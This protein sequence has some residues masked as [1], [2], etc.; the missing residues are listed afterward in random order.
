MSEL[1]VTQRTKLVRLYK[2]AGQPFVATTKPYISTRPIPFE[3]ADAQ[4]GVMAHAVCRK[5][6]IPPFFG[7][8]VGALVPDGLGGGA[9][10]EATEDM[11]NLENP[12]STNGSED[13]VIE[14]VSSTAKCMRI[15]YAD[16]VSAAL[17]DP[18]VIASYRGLRC[19]VDPASLEFVP[20]M[21]SP[22][23]LELPFMSA[24]TPMAQIIFRWGKKRVEYIGRLD[25][26]PE[27]GAK[28]FLRANGDPRIDN[29]Y[30]IPEGYL[31][32]R[33]GQPDSDFAMDLIIPTAF[34][35][36]ITLVPLLGT[37]SPTVV[38]QKIVLDLTIRTHGL[39]VD[40]PTS[41]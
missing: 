33:K 16:T 29:R 39:S 4:A 30:R 6:N 3:I 41:N 32:R 19:V 18:D 5:Q 40:M 21:N 31:W 9:N 2:K 15:K 1:F 22:F 14:G 11:T 17:T 24:L 10:M 37:T 13:F 38:P 34:L 35:V 7:Y 26:I 25:E 36:P 8:G 12:F 23:N 20:Q 28:S 27:G